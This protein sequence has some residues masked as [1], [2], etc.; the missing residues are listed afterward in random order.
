MLPNF[1]IVLS[2]ES[3]TQKCAVNDTMPKLNVLVDICV[4]PRGTSQMTFLS[5]LSARP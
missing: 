4:T 5:G 2:G 1:I 3:P